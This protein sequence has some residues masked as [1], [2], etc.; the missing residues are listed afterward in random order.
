M[1]TDARR[2]TDGLGIWGGGIAGGL[3]G[4]IGM[5]LV[6]H[7]GANQIHLLGAFVGHPTVLGG[8]V[9]HLTFSVLFGMA[10]AAVVSSPLLEPFTE[11][12]TSVVGLGVTYGVLLGLFAGGLLLPLSLARF[13]VGV[14]PAPFLPLP[15][16]AG[17]LLFALL[18]ALA[19]LVYGVLLGSVYAMINGLAPAGVV[20]R[21]PALGR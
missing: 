9:A 19:H 10:F 8:W 5:G 14:Y 1:N 18:L 3:V 7:L 16:V 2:A 21:V 4:G 12:F 11:T 6:L 13:G 20:E 17:E 15:G